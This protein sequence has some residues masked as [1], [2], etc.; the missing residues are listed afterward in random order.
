MKVFMELLV[1]EGRFVAGSVFV[2]LSNISVFNHG[3]Q[4]GLGHDF[5]C[6]VEWLLMSSRE[7]LK[8]VRPNETV[9]MIRNLFCARFCIVSS[10]RRNRFGRSPVV[11]SIICRMVVII[12]VI[13][14]S[15]LMIGE[16]GHARSWKTVESL[17][18]VR[19]R[20]CSMALDLTA[21]EAVNP[22]LVGTSMLLHNHVLYILA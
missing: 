13:K 11:S 1:D 5:T 7:S 22:L 10:S 18:R 15:W 14:C 9:V 4:D 12:T 19:A 2:D 16:P 21:M 20:S 6:L 3:L 8:P 17:V